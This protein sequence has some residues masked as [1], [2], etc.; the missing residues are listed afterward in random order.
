[1]DLGARGFLAQA[2]LLLN[3]C[4]DV[5][6]QDEPGIALMPLF[7]SIRATIRAHALA[8]QA[9]SSPDLDLAAKALH[10]LALADDLLAPVSPRLVAIGGLSGTG[11][12]NIAKLVAPRSEEHTSALQSL[13]RLSSPVCSSNQKK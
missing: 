2:Y 10:Y 8:A 5:S 6:P 13:L 1:M 3:R 11:Q 9:V 7:L 4:R 12:S